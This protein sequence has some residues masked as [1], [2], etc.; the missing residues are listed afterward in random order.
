MTKKTTNTVWK[1]AMQAKHSPQMPDPGLQKIR[2]YI[3]YENVILRLNSVQSEKTFLP[4]MIMEALFFLHILE[5][6]I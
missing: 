1:F 2:S 5:P 3:I 4:V 6:I